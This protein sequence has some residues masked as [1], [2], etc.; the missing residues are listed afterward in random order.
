MC[1]WDRFDRKT[2]LYFTGNRGSRVP[3]MENE[4]SRIGLEGAERQ[5]NFPCPLDR[6]IRKMIPHEG[7]VERDGYFNCSMGH[8][9]AIS[10]AYH[11]GAEHALFMEDD[12]R[13]LNDTS[14]IECAVAALP[15]DYDVAMM[16]WFCIKKRDG[17]G[18]ALARGW[19]D[20]R[21]VNAYWSEFDRLFSAGCY[22]L[23]RIG[24][25]RIMLGFELSATDR[26]NGKFR[27]IDHYMDRNVI[28]NGARMYFAGK[29]IAIQREIG[30]SNSSGYD[31]AEK[32]KALGIRMEDYAE[33]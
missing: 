28:G 21:R 9:R 27:I 3:A 13:F 15:D 7:G 11:L 30:S 24:M 8:Y 1:C 29:N 17:S 2:V 33:A 26:K 31:I 16:D 6:T 20:E 4:L 25:E 32:Y 14:E 5:W 22:A 23:S 12:I 19:R 18:I 10:T